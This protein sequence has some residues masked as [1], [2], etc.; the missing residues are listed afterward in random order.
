ML[1][2]NSI[3]SRKIGN[4]IDSGNCSLTHQLFLLQETYHS[5]SF[6]TRILIAIS[7]TIH[8]PH[9][10]HIN[11]LEALFEQQHLSSDGDEIFSGKMKRFSGNLKLRCF[12]PQSSRPIYTISTCYQP[13]IKSM[14][15][16]ACCKENSKYLYSHIQNTIFAQ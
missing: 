16:H 1:S 9:M 3:L 4:S 6:R 11:N 2:A 7:S 12:T 5:F 15:W 13:T 10:C 8:R 14:V